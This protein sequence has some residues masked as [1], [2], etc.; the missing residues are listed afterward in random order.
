[1]QLCLITLS[2]FNLLQYVVLLEAYEENAASHRYVI[3][4]RRS[5]L[6][7]FSSFTGGGHFFRDC[8]RVIFYFCY[9]F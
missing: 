6:I 2:A 1:M 3:G 7:V 5:F 9:S 8:E 4:K